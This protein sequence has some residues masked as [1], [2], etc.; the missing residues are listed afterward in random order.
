MLTSEQSGSIIDGLTA[1]RKNVT[2]ALKGQTECKHQYAIHLRN[3]TDPC[4]LIS[5]AICYSIIDA[6]RQLPSKRCPT[7]KNLFHSGCL[8]KWFKTS[9]ASTCPLCRNSFNFN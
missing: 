9:N 2:G 1:W 4:P 3:I 8:V 6:H 7:C 5:G